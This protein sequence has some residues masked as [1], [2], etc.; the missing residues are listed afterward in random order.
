ML[1]LRSVSLLHVGDVGK[2]AKEGRVLRQAVLLA[3]TSLHLRDPLSE[4][5]AVCCLSE[6]DAACRSQWQSGT[7]PV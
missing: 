4:L 1:F 7:P 2:I 6:A 5:A 3:W